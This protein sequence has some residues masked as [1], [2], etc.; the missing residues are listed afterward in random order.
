MLLHRG[1]QV[2]HKRV[3]RLWRLEGLHVQRS[4]R[5]KPKIARE[6]VVVCG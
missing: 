2:N 6:P 5:R 4:K 3:Q 1:Y